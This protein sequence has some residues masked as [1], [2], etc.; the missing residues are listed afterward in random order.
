M[1]NKELLMIGGSYTNGTLPT[2]EEFKQVVAYIREL[3]PNT[4]FIVFF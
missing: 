3:V 1:L 2:E 4:A